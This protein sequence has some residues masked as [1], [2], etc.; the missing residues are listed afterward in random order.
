MTKT[1]IFALCCIIAVQ[2]A[3]LYQRTKERENELRNAYQLGLIHCERE[4]LC[5]NRLQYKVV[6][7]CDSIEF[8][9]WLTHRVN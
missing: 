5:K 7:K 3:L 2:G 9:Y 8:E 4:S 6:Q 1:V